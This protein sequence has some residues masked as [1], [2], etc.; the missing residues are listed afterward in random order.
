MIRKLL[1]RYHYL[2]YIVMSFFILDYYIRCINKNVVN[3]SLWDLSPNFFTISWILLF[4]MIILLF[5]GKLKKIIYIITLFFFQLML[6]VNY[7][8][9]GV[10]TT[11]F[12]FKSIG[13]AE[14]GK[15]YFK[16]VYN[17]IDKSLI[18]I[19]IISILLSVIACHFMPKDGKKSDYFMSLGLLVTAIVF[20]ISA[21][22]N[23][24]PPAP[25][26]SWKTWNYNKNIY[27]S[28]SDTR[29]SI[30]IAGLYE[31][32]IRDIYLSKIMPI[33]VNNKESIKYVDKYFN[34]KDNINT[35]GYLH[36]IYKDKNVIVVLMESIDEWLLTNETMPTVNKLM[37]EGINFTNHYAPVYGGGATANAEFMINTGY[38]TP[39]N[40]ETASNKYGKNYFPYSLAS[41]FK[42]R[43][44]SV[45][46][47]HQNT[48]AYYNRRQMSQAF[49]YDNYY[50]SRELGVTYNKAIKDSHFITESKIKKLLLP[51]SGKF[52]DF[53]IT[54]TAHTPYNIGNPKCS[55]VITKED[56]N[57]LK[58]GGSEETI[59]IKA[60][61]KETDKFFKEL[62]KELTA[63]K[64]LDNT[65]I[66]GVTD[67]YTYAYNNRNE[68]Y[69]LKGTSDKNLISRVPFFIWSNDKKAL[70]IK[71]VNSDIDILP[72]I[73]DLFAL[74]Y[75]PK[76][77]LGK[78]I[79]NENYKG[80]VFF[81]DYS[82]YDG[83]T[84]YKNSTNSNK[85]ISSVTNEVNNI[86]DINKRVLET[87]YFAKFKSK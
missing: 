80:F 8:Y 51:T 29:K 11:F 84:Y 69:E 43:D 70:K 50:S 24:G 12:S 66:I 37:N 20:Y 74:D 15:E 76:Y 27:D 40:G 59:C 41:L 30:E 25:L 45:N 62:I 42:E 55:S 67:H 36:G 22:I 48:G 71:S 6:F 18:I 23:L 73:A 14:E 10:F 35:D 49:G 38:M 16:L 39:L 3:T 17:Y 72:T 5:K 61:A 21:I 13:L 81:S 56:I 79:F 86:I 26:N 2:L 63:T 47:F 34:T 65:V 9:Y 32:I 28:F 75:N 57:E 82:W 87:N 33:I 60:Q 19:L 78:N 53:I 64:Q 44:Y 46:F 7:I 31:Y 54:Y 68:V 4:I 83:K 52:F 85:Y 77:Y 58:K 1:N